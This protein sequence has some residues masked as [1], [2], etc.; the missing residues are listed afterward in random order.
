MKDLLFLGIFGCV[1]LLAL[2]LGALRRKPPASGA[3]TIG[4]LLPG[5]FWL[6]AIVVDWGNGGR[7]EQYVHPRR[8]DEAFGG[9]TLPYAVAVGLIGVIGLGAGVLFARRARAVGLPLGLG[10][11]VLAAWYLCGLGIKDVPFEVLDWRASR[12]SASFDR[13]IMWTPQTFVAFL[14]SCALA[15]AGAGTAIGITL[16]GARKAASDGPARSATG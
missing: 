12:P 7:V 5:L 11:V 2:A 16:R 8:L 3:T 10:I 1:V 4:P 15:L 9:G 13:W 6:Y 14:G